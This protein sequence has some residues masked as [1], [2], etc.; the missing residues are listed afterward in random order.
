MPR[1]QGNV[2]SRKRRQKY[3]KAAKGNFGGRRKLY[4][5]ARETVEKGWQYQFRDRRNRKREFRRLWIAR[6]NAAV[7]EL[8]LSYSVF[9]NAVKK[10]GVELDRKML[11]DLAAR[12]PEAFKAIVDSVRTPDLRVTPPTLPLA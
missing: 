7:R 9:M 2:P 1:A 6:I 4:R 3:L 5:T 10:A 11:A 12:Q 8:G